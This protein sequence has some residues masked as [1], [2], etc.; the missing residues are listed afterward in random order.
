MPDLPK[1]MKGIQILEPGGPDVLV[2]KVCELPI[3]KNTEVL[4]KVHAAGVN[5]PDC[6]QRAGLY[7]APKD[8]S[9]LPGLEVSGEIVATGTNA[10]DWNVG[11]KVAALTHGGGYAEYCAAEFSHCLP[12]P[13]GLSAEEAATLPETTFTVYHNLMDRGE[14]QRGE[15]V[16]IHGGSSGIGSTAIQIAKAAGA[17]VIVTAGSQEKCD[18]CLRLGADFAIDYNTS[19]FVQ[20]VRDIQSDSG[21]DVILDMVAGAYV[22]K[23]IGLLALDGR[24]IMIAFLGGIRAEINFGQFLAKRLVLK[25]STLRPQSVS[26]KAVIASQVL[27]HVWPLVVDG[28]VTSNVYASFPLTDASEAHRLME[29]SGHLGKIVLKVI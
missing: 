25:G 6:L 28:Q 5:R 11:D 8:A 27:S 3:I 29:S 4:I 2:P 26:Q 1:D 9:A 20:E 18:Y 23:N 12:W 13:V 17:T 7:V 22:K 24:Y 21:V 14:L 15:V 19:D 16:L 10:G